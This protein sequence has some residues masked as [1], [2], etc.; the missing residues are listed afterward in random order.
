MSGPKHTPTFDEIKQELLKLSPNVRARVV[1]ACNAH[2]DL[3]A[4]R[5][6]LL[7][8]CKLALAELRRLDDIV[9][10]IEAW[11]EDEAI[12][13]CEAAIREAKP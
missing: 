13:A 3:V 10:D 12:E 6:Q 4:E 8:A 11:V 1:L 7:A 9:G 2:D 5:G